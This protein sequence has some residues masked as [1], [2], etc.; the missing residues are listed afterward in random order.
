MNFIFRIK[1]TM[2]FKTINLYNVK[3]YVLILSLIYSCT[4][5]VNINSVNKNQLNKETSLYLKQH[6]ENPINWQRWS[7]SIFDV[8]QEL[9]KLLVIS[10]GYSSC[11]WCHVMEEETFTNDSIAKV[12]NAN[13]INIKVDREEN[14]DVDQAYMTASQL[15]TGMGG[16][17]LNVITLPDGSPIYAGTYH[18]T[19]QWNDILKRIV[20]LKEDNYDGLK[21]IAANVK[22]GVKDVNTIQKQEEI[23]DFNSEFLNSNIEGWMER[24]DLEFGG[25]I[26]QQKFVSP[27]KYL[28]LLN[29]GR[30]YKDQKVLNHVKNTLDII[31]SSGLNDFIEGGFYRYTVDNEWKI[32]HF[33]KMLYDQAQ[34]ISLFSMGYKV[35]GDQS[36]KDIVSNT[37]LFLSNKMSSTDGLYYAAM[38]ADTDGE[39]GKYYSYEMDE[40]KMISENTDF[41]LFLSYYNIDVENPWEKNRFLLLPNKFNYE[42]KWIDSNNVS[43]KEI[44]DLITIWEKN[45]NDIKEDR[46][47]PRIDDKIIVSWN[48]LAIIGLIDAYDAF[49]NEDYISIAKSMFKELKDNSYRKGQLIH[50][51]KENQFQEGVLE[52]Y[53]YLS[54]AA[55]RLFQAT[56]DISYFDFSKKVIDNALELFND[57]QSDLLKYSNNEELFTKVI[58]IDDGVTPSPNSIIAEQLF[59]IG[60]VIFDDEYLDLSDK[61]VSAVQKIIDGNINSYSVWA[62]NILNRVESF[63]EI[64]VIG[65]NAKLITDEITKNFTPNTIVVQSNIESKIPLFIDRFFE[66]ET[67]IYV[68]Q[69]KTCQRPETNIKLALEQV[70]YIN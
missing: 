39:E 50:T 32:P 24:W 16:W 25:D 21:E 19:S 70:P 53:A 66:D 55:M 15:M 49:K 41:D 34:M 33:E 3:F 61:M 65:P 51:Y 23:S 60:H 10:I 18:T 58:S 68:C 22:N 43:K 9:D 48:A 44:S 40:L 7:N 20:R 27:S 29:Y 12:M 42:K 59:S 52:D 47:K 35:F 45:I 13:F 28:F 46:T 36:F 14:P 64:A 62:N 8:S 63:Y 2:N 1:K 37:I 30:I 56:G 57:E 54:K 31:A 69:N 17:P 6:S 5:E 38:D 4:S 26:A 11:H 67:Y